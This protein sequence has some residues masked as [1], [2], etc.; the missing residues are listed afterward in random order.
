MASVGVGFD[1]PTSRT[2]MAWSRT[3]LIIAVLTA[4]LVRGVV[5]LAESRGRGGGGGGVRGGVV[6]GGVGRRGPRAQDG[7]RAARAVS[8]VLVIL[9]A[10][11]IGIGLARMR[12]LAKYGAQAG[13][14][15]A[16]RT[17]LWLTAGAL[18][19]AAVGVVFALT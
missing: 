3:L 10:V 14:R 7:G 13:D 9:S 16:R 6:G 17:L 1:D 2:R 15:P 4:L 19:M 11:M 18:G 5:V 8:I 12:R